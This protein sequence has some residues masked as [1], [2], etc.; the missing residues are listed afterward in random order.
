MLDA[1]RRPEG[2]FFYW[3]LTAFLV[4]VFLMWSGIE[5]PMAWAASPAMTT[6]ADVVYRADGSPAS[7][8]V[9]ISW[10]AFTAADGTPVAA[11]S[12][13]VALGNEG[14]LSVDLVPNAGASPNAYYTAVFQLD[15]V[16]R[17]E[18]WLV[19][20]TS[21]ATL[22]S[23]RATPGS[24]VPAQ[25]VSR[26]YVDAAVAANK[27][28]VDAAVSTVGSES[29]VAKTG[30]AM[31]GPLNLANDPTSSSQ[32]ANK[33]Y[34]D[35]G[36][37]SKANLVGGVVPPAQLGSGSA[38]G[39]QCLKGN[40]SWGACGTSSNATTIQNVAVATNAPSD[41]QVITYDAAS[42]KYMPKTGAGPGNAT[43]LQGVPVDSS[44]PSDGQV[45]T[46]DGS[47]GKYKPKPGSGLSAAQQAVKYAGDF[48]WTS[49]PATSLATAGAQ[50][51]SLAS[52][53]AGVFATFPGYYNTV[54]P[55]NVYWIY[56]SGTGTPEAA[57]VT[58]GT[59]NG[60]GNPGTLKFSTVNA[61]PAGYTLS[62]ATGGVQEASMAAVVTLV[63]GNNFSYKFNGTVRVGPGTFQF[64]APLNILASNQVLDFSGSMVVCNF[65]ADCINVGT[66]TSPNPTYGVTIL[67]PMGIPTVPNSHHAFL[68]DYAFK[69]KFD[70]VGEYQGKIVGGQNST[71]GYGVVNVSDQAM[72]LDDMTMNNLTC[73]SDFVGAAVYAPGP[74]T[75]HSRWPSAGDNTAVGWISHLNLSFGC[76]NG[77][78]WQSGNVLRI[79]D[80]VI[81]G[82]G[83]FAVRTGLSGPQGSNGGYGATVID[84]LYTE[85]GGA[86]NPF[87][88]IGIAGIIVNGG[89]LDMRGGEGP[90]GTKPLFANTGSTDNWYYVLPHSTTYGYGNQLF[91][92]H[93][94][95]NGTGNITVTFAEPIG[96]TDFTLLKVPLATA[97]YA[98]PTGTGNYAVVI[99][100]LD[101]ANCTN[102]ICTYVDTQA[103]L[104]SITMP[105]L[106]PTF[107]PILPLGVGGIVLGGGASNFTTSAAVASVSLN[108]L[109]NVGIFQ[110]NVL[111]LQ[112]AAVHSQQCLTSIGAPLYQACE[113]SS[114]QG[115]N[116][117]TLM[118]GAGT[119]DGGGNLNKKGRLNFLASG[120]GP[121]HIVT[122]VD[123]NP[124]KTV[125]ANGSH[126]PT[127]DAND[128]F[129]GCDSVYCSTSN[130]GISL[131]APLSI[132][133]YIGNAGDGTS[134]KERLTAAA[135]TF[136]VNV[137]APAFNAT[138]GVQVGGSYGA[139]GQCLTSTGTGSAWAACGSG[140]GGTSPL[141]SKGDLWGFGTANARIPVGAD[142]Q[143][144]VADSTNAVGVKWGSCGSGSQDS[145]LVHTSGVET[146]GGD[147][148]FSGNVTFQGVMLVSGA[149]QVES[150]GPVAAMTV[151]TGD[152][153][154]GFDSDGKLKVS[155]NGGAVT[156]LA[157]VSQIPAAG[158]CTNKVVTATNASGPPTCTTVSSAY[159]DSSIASTATL[160]NGNYAKASGGAALADSG[161][162]AGPYTMPWLTT[163]RG[164][165]P[166]GVTFSTTANQA[167]LWGVVLSFPIT[168]TQVR[169]YVGTAD[170]TANVYDIGIYD[171]AGNLKAHLGP[172]AGTSF[173]P[174]AAASYVLPWTASVTL[175][176]G[177]YYLA[178]TTNCTASCATLDGDNASGVTFQN[179]GT[180]SVTSGTLSGSVTPPADSWSWSAY[181]P[182]WVVY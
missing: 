9:L 11:G 93:A 43:A 58:G 152:S 119:Q 89:Y 98:A 106:P 74:F 150:T 180:V 92:G 37:A 50:T 115:S 15:D 113:G 182:A 54:T 163:Q 79:S 76:Q 109:N 55:P 35:L 102:G 124:T 148:T 158:G 73:A 141:T 173:A 128:A 162:A 145:S 51:V 53:P 105:S 90:D 59:C 27:A 171:A 95:T 172:K 120:S 29:Y 177:K 99:G 85:V 6:V 18:Y 44:T 104:Q 157:K 13:S 63:S 71:F 116:M 56:V 130:T 134:W 7:G 155:E 176:P 154:V 112:G 142:G 75:G 78:D 24:G 121:T 57:L 88:N 86:T 38:D 16:V 36:L 61:H 110:N 160:V 108:N 97:G 181:T 146:I 42:A 28:Y 68:V 151:G 147:K 101:S 156:E 169:Y 66:W 34:V 175:Q 107:F 20:T 19:G 82:Y 100:A 5:G 31:S 179:G 174:V 149:W 22:A 125:N 84:N 83:Q 118:Q 12:T 67:S 127:N 8:V 143:C 72:T 65:D 39:T 21:P 140:G 168:T 167:K 30:D 80:S 14:G 48:A 126:R 69:T 33:H 135:K 62:S 123:S 136:T 4:S 23:V 170:N 131:G 114:G 111:G 60:D 17:T 10:P 3:L 47:S 144:L 40:S 91:V 87:G 1:R 26:Q 64:Y 96:A 166:S 161:V 137:T 178:I 103:A 46:Y 25:T 32:A 164:G 159:V 49:S 139:S 41:G 2:R 94:L 153:K 165:S 117:A 122:L 129:L 45:V 81:Q 133:N 70:H 132:S 138:T 52:C 77:V